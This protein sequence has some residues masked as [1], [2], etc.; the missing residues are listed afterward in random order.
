MLTRLR[1]AVRVQVLSC[2]TFSPKLTSSV[3][4]SGLSSKDLLPTP[5]KVLILNPTLCSR[6]LDLFVFG[7]PD[8]YK[9][10][11]PLPNLGARVFSLSE[12]QKLSSFV[13]NIQV[14]DLAVKSVSI[15][16][17]TG[18]IISS[19]T[20]TEELLQHDW[21]LKLNN[22]SFHIKSPPLAKGSITNIFFQQTEPF[23]GTTSINSITS[24]IQTSNGF[25][26][27][28]CSIR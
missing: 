9:L 26:S 2:C 25:F 15:T 28:P 24:T 10:A 19:N 23:R 3:P 21:V 6:S 8:D 18:A 7:E 14:E 5:L 17:T 11:I 12:R 13:E 20:K 4:S 27:K 22:N 1:P 16:D